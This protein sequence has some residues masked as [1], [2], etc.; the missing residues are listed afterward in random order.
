MNVRKLE[1]I[2]N[3][4]IMTK[5]LSSYVG[6]M[7]ICHKLQENYRSITFFFSCCVGT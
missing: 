2:E 6:Q 1:Q 3:D 5:S 4:L 7:V